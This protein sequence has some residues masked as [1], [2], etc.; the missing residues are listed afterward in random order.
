MK[1]PCRDIKKIIWTKWR[2]LN[3]TKGVTRRPERPRSLKKHQRQM[4]KNRSLKKHQSHQ[5]L[6]MIQARI[7]RSLEKYQGQAIE[8]MLLQKQEKKLERLRGLKK[9]QSHLNLLTQ[10]RNKR[11]L[12]CWG[13]K[14]KP[15]VFLIFGR[16]VKIW[17]SRKR[18][19]LWRQWVITCCVIWYWI[20]QGVLKM[21]GLDK[22]TKHLIK[23]ALAKT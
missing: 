10:A 13:W 19:I 16:R 14:K 4:R 1:R 18:G 5:G 12:F 23:K 21:S 3:S 17:Q 9:H 7:N 20:P 15:K 22:K 6:L 8:K 11:S 2:L